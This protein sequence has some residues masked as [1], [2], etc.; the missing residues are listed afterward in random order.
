MGKGNLFWQ[1]PRVGVQKLIHCWKK[2]KRCS[3]SDQSKSWKVRVF[4]FFCTYATQNALHFFVFLN[5]CSLTS[6]MTSMFAFIFLCAYFVIDESL[7]LLVCLC[8]CLYVSVCFSVCVCVSVF[9]FPFLP[10]HTQCIALLTTDRQVE[11]EL[12]EDFR[13]EL[14]W[15]TQ[16]DWRIVRLRAFRPEIICENQKIKFSNICLWQGPKQ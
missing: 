13:I 14:S 9:V 11:P 4:L 3:G 2:A 16:C 12:G 5:F 7:G 1:I 10:R 6:M 15:V 8:V